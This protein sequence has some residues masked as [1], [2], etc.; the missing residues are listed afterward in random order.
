MAGDIFLKNSDK[1]DLADILLLFYGLAKLL[2]V[3]LILYKNCEELSS[4]SH[5]TI[6]HHFK[7]YNSDVIYFF[8][9]HRHITFYYFLSRVYFNI[10][11]YL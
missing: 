3:S 6:I 8:K 11:S 5:S 1:F 10:C 2:T 7:V 4:L 9:I